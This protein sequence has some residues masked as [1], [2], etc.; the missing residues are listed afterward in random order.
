MLVSDGL[1]VFDPVLKSDSNGAGTVTDLLPP[2]LLLNVSRAPSV[3][4][5]YVADAGGGAVPAEICAFTNAMS[6]DCDVTLPFVAA[7][8]FVAA[9]AH[10]VAIA[11]IVVVSD[12]SDSSRTKALSPFTSVICTT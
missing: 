5:G 1:T 11:A 9:A 12:T 10:W 6:N 2:A 8:R 4:D 7:A 3:T